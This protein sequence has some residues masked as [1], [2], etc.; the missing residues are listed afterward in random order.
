MTIS[1]K[2]EK[3]VAVDATRGITVN[4]LEG[5]MRS[6]VSYITKTLTEVLK[7]PLAITNSHE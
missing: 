2:C 5:R 4:P 7:S 6:E 3:F 1:Q